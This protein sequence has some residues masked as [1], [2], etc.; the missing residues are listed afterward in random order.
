MITRLR[1][2]VARG[3]AGPAIA[4][5]LSAMRPADKPPLSAEA[6]RKKACALGIALR[7]VRPPKAN[8]GFAASDT[9]TILQKRAAERGVNAAKLAAQLLTVIVADGLVGAVLDVPVRR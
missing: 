2:M 4:V 8:F 6:I 7:P 3:Y 5:A 9:R 1:E